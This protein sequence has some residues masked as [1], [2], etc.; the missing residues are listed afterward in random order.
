MKKLSRSEIEAT[1]IMKS[2]TNL[3]F[4]KHPHVYEVKVHDLITIDTSPNFTHITGVY[5]DLKKN[6]NAVKLYRINNS[7][8]MKRQVI[9]NPLFGL[10]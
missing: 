10:Q 5:K 9:L 7:T 1:Q 4:R 3:D 2:D 8:G 6:G